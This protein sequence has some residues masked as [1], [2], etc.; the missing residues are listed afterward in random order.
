MPPLARQLS[1]APRGGCRCVA[2][3]SS[4]VE[5]HL[6][7]GGHPVE[8]VHARTGMRVDH[9]EINPAA[10][11]SPPNWLADH[12]RTQQEP[13]SGLVRIR[14]TGWMART[15]KVEIAARKSA[16]VPGRHGKTC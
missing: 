3:G 6:S 8:V 4:P 2:V 14:R 11:Q 15:P 5:G 1:C 12:E 10:A 9:K 16:L 13:R 7:Q